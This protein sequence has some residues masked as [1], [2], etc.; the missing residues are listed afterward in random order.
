MAR[1]PAADPVLQMAVDAALAKKA[2]GLVVLDLRGLSDVTD[3]FI[4]CHGRST[5]QA[6]TVSDAIEEALRARKRKPKHI[7]GYSRGEWIL[8]DY[9][10]FVVHV[11]TEERRSYY[12]LEKL[13][14][15]APRLFQDGDEGEEAEKGPRRAS[16]TRSRKS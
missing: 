3:Y 15:D 11:F 1:R 4:I 9:I 10:D 14:G 5:R 12:A 8:M 13:W 2:E 7:E 6:Q 16:G